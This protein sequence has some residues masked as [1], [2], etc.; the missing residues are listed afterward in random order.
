MTPDKPTQDGDWH[1]LRNVGY[2][3]HID[4]TDHPRTFPILAVGKLLLLHSGAT[5]ITVG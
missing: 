2:H 3:L 1:G 5:I 4:K